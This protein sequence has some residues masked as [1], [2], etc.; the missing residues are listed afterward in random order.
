MNLTLDQLAGKVGVTVDPHLEQDIEIPVLSGPQA[1]GDLIVLPFDS[2]TGIGL[3]HDGWTDVPPQGV[4]LV[5]GA[6]G[7]NVHLLV[8]DPGVCR[9]STNVTDPEGL[10]VGV[11][12]ATAP[13]HL[14][15]REHGGSGIAPGRYLIRRQREMA[16]VQR[17]VAD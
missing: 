16:D 17:L 4:E 13:V 14:I 9:W 5:R 7:G 3:G 8:A 6:A 2:V 1:Q 15:H 10:A 11:L 12:D